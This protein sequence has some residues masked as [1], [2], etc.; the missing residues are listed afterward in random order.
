M[1]SLNPIDLQEL[2][3]SVRRE[4]SLR[5][6]QG[7]VADYIPELA[8]ID[9]KKLGIAV[10]TIDGDFVSCGDTE[11]LFSIQSISK[12]FTLALALGK[13]GDSLWERVGREP[14]GSAFNS[15]V[16]LEHERGIPRNPFINAGAI[17]VADI[18]LA[19]H[20]PREAIGHILQFVR[21]LVNDETIAIDPAIARSETESGYRNR[22]LANYMRAFGNLMRPNTWGL[23]SPMCHCHELQ[24]VGSRRAV[25]RQ[26]RTNSV[27]QRKC[28]I[29]SA[30]SA[31]QCSYADLWPIRRLRRL[32]F[33]GRLAEQEWSGRRYSRH[34]SGPSFDCGVVAGTQHG[35]QLFD[36]NV[37][38]RADSKQSRLVGLLAQSPSIIHSMS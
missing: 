28:G 36:R 12:V 8:R 17:V 31:N 19:G 24:S 5:L 23:F 34:C 21:F 10:A 38:P 33:S 18:V 13:V 29:A 1:R 3:E 35:R 30:L 7:R 27:I 16:Q 11:D 15:I 2:I 37:C 32:R 4:A 20:Q 22:A 26:W 9:A 25:S 6:G 14:S